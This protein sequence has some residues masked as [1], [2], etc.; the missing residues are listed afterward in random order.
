M[1]GREAIMRRLLSALTKSTPDHL[2][3]VGPRFAGKTV[4]LNELACRLREAGAPYTA[5][6]SW[7]L[8]HQSPGTDELF[9]QRLARELSRALRANHPDYADL[10]KHPEGNPYH[11]IAEVLEALKGEGSKVLAI[12]DGFD[13]PLSNGLLTRNLWDQLRQLALTPSLRLVTASR[14]A[15]RELIRNPEAQTSDFWSIFEPNPVRVGCFDEG[16]LA[17]VLGSLPGLE[18]AAGAHTE[19]L[20][21]SNGFPV[22]VLEILN[23][24]C[25]TTSTGAVSVEVMRA[26]CNGAFLSLRERIEALWTDCS[27]SCQDLLRR[28]QEQGALTRTAGSNADADALIERG[29]VHQTG[30]RLLRPN[31]LLGNYLEERPNEGSALARLFGTADVYQKHFKGVLERRIAQIAG[32]DQALKRYLERGVEDLPDHPNVF[33]GNVHGILEQTLMLIWKAECWNPET[34]RPRIPSSWFSIWKTNEERG[35]EDWRTRFP[36][37]GQRLHL[38]DLITGTQRTDRL[39][40]FVTKNTY[41]LANGVQGFR[42]FGVHPKTADVYL[43]TAY[44]A[45]NLCVELAATVALELATPL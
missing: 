7:D 2:Q 19:L 25:E 3:V 9:M 13:K 21:A 23:T 20:N 32:I 38:L 26:A 40:R 35:F 14:R 11:E 10:L 18:L 45:L 12:M 16:D 30:N 6:M 36:D 37:G 5:I 29:F 4:I 27:P 39:A 8:G 44:A 28:V 42:D 24:L 17:A 15:L 43:G 34:N 41:V 33:L 31:A 1:L 22:I